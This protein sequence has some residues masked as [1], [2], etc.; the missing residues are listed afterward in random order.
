[1]PLPKFEEANTLSDQELA[2]QIV[3]VKRQLFE[4]RM[5]KGTRQLEKPHQFKHAKHQ[6]SQLLTVERSRQLSKE[7]AG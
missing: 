2:D 3:A 4:L 7:Q 6:L 1:M 5:Q